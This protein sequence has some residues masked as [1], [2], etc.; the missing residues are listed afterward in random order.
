MASLS[1]LIDHELCFN[2]KACEVACK[3]EHNLPTGPRWITVETVGPK[4]IG[5][6]LIAD[7]I[8]TT[9]HHCGKPPCADACPTDAIMKREDGIV[10]IDPEL[11][12]GCQSCFAACPW[13]VIQ[14][15]PEKNIA[16][17][18]D[19]CLGRVE[20]GLKPAC[21]QHCEA[22]AIYFGDI[23]QIAQQMRRERAQRKGLQV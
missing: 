16:E 21:A 6:R 19:M 13:G 20:K 8:P 9:C 23:N 22:G 3:Q 17:K 11:C 10:V 7:F 18:C 4:K 5:D 1:L 12:N 15:D 2:C 14:F